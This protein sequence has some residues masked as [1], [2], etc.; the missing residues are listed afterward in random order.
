MALYRYAERA[1]LLGGVAETV[2]AQLVIPTNGTGWET[3]LRTAP[4]MTVPPPQSSR[5]KIIA[6]LRS[7]Y[8]D[9]FIGTPWR[10][11]WDLNSDGPVPA[12]SRRRPTWLCFRRSRGISLKHV[13]PQRT[14]GDRP[15]PT[16]L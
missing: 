4:E 14:S 5:G 10:W 16:F 7:A 12:N 11:R 13:G 2:L 8:R 15:W 3:Q 9:P 1:V 6:D